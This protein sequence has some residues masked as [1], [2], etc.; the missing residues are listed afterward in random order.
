MNNY[1]FSYG[2][3]GMNYCTIENQPS[4]IMRSSY[5]SL[6]K[7]HRF[8]KNEDFGSYLNASTL[9]ELKS[10]KNY[11]EI[12]DSH[13]KKIVDSIHLLRGYIFKNSMDNQ[14]QYPI[15]LFRLI[16]NIK[17][18]FSIDNLILSNLN[19]LYIINR[20]EELEKEL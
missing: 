1:P 4:D 10:T 12:L 6:E 13:F 8:F 5:E 19:P 17:N 18:K 9:K 14:I 20:I 16:N 7:T 3:D 15:N 11:M 2:E